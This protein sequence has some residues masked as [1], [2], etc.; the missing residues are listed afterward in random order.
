MFYYTVSTKF[1]TCSEKEGSAGKPTCFFFS[2]KIC[3]S[4]LAISLSTRSILW[5]SSSLDSLEGDVSWS[6]PM[7]SVCPP[8]DGDSTLTVNWDSWQKHM[9]GHWANEKQQDNICRKMNGYIQYSV[10]F[11]TCQKAAFIFPVVYMKIQQCTFQKEVVFSHHGG[12]GCESSSAVNN[13]RAQ[14]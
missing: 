11:C 4:T 6:S 10:I 2:L 8:G 3:C 12:K 9:K 7:C 14:F 5:I 1:N 13:G